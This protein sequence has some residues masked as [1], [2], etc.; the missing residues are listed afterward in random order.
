[1]PRQL[2]ASGHVVDA[3]AYPIE[4]A[5]SLCQVTS[6]NALGAGTQR[7]DGSNHAARQ[8]HPGQNGKTERRK[9]YNAEPLQSGIERRIGLRDGQLDEDQPAKGRNR[10]IGSVYAR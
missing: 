1:V 2:S 6:A 5:N 4:D 7:L 9:Q 10:R 3:Q 8:K